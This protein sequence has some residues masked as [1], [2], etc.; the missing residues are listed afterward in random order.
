ME[1]FALGGKTESVRI[2]LDPLAGAGKVVHRWSTWVPWTVVGGGVVAAAVGGLF[3]ARAVS[4][5]DTYSAAIAGCGSTGCDPNY[6][7]DLKDRA[8]LENR[9][10]IGLFVAGGAAVIT[11]GAMLYLNRGHTVYPNH[12]EQLVPTASLTAG[13]AIVG[14]A[15]EL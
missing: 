14:V 3:E 9:T 5:R 2:A 15:G 13:G 4:N 10:A 12:T 6:R 11:G 8:L 1:L 7:L